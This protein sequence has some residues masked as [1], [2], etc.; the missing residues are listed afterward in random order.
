AVVGCLPRRH[1]GLGPR[2][3]QRWGRRRGGLGARVGRGLRRWW[4]GTV[5]LGVGRCKSG[6]W[7]RW[8]VG[9]SRGARW[10]PGG[11]GPG[12]RGSAG[13]RSR[14]GGGAIGCRPA[15]GATTGG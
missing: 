15:A 8:V 13:G 1:R 6:V 12:W 14:R 9:E 3:G 7:A 4:E 2:V 5:V 10:R 11:G